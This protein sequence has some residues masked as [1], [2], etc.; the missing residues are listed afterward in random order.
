MLKMTLRGIGARR[1]RSIL[2]AL[3]V[4]F[5]VAMIA[6]TLMLTDSVNGSF[7]DIFVDINSGTDVSV[8]TRETIED[9]RGALPQAFDELVLDEVRAAAGVAEAAGS[10]FDPTVSVLDEQGARVGPDGPPHFAGSVLPERFS[11]WTY[12]EGR[13]P[14]TAEEIGIDSLSAEREDW[15]LG[16]SVRIAGVGAAKE[17]AIS[18]IAEFGSGVELR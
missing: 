1:T 10:V 2:T 9:S 13:A 12:I 16:D 11:P 5:G 3:S 18:G 4:F 14:E 7:D 15:A 17:Y 8:T 6:G